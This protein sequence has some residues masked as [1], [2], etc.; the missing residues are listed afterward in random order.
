MWLREHLPHPHHE[1]EAGAEA[2][3][4]SPAEAETGDEPFPGYSRMNTHQLVVDLHN[5]SQAVLAA[6]EQ[7]EL[8]HDNRQAV[9]NKLHY[10][11][12]AEPWKGY[13]EMDEEEIIA[14]LQNADD[15]TVKRVRDYEHKFFNRP[16][17]IEATIHLHH[18][19]MAALGPREVPPYM[20]GGG[21]GAGA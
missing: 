21:V 5:H 9:L 12:G 2:P 3:A 6:A 15:N 17:L 7:Y 14:R 1:E 11:R 8:T 10:L 18:E 13:D 16:R 20:P 19:H 4:R